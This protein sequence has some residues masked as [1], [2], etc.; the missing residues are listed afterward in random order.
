MDK[1]FRS[2][3][4]L[5]L[6]DQNHTWNEIVEL[7]QWDN[8][9]FHWVHESVVSGVDNIITLTKQEAINNI[10]NSLQIDF[11]INSQFEL[12]Y[13]NPWKFIDKYEGNELISKSFECV[14]WNKLTLKWWEPFDFKHKKLNKS[15][16]SLKK[17]LELPE[18][19]NDYFKNNLLNKLERINVSCR[20]TYEMK[21]SRA[22]DKELLWDF[23]QRI[24]CKKI[25]WTPRLKDIPYTLIFETLWLKYLDQWVYREKTKKELTDYFWNHQEY[26]N[27]KSKRHEKDV[28][29]INKDSIYIK[30]FFHHI[31]KNTTWNLTKE[32]FEKLFIWSW[33]K[34]YTDLSI[35]ESDST[36]YLK[37]SLSI[38]WVNDLYNWVKYPL[39]K[40]K[41]LLSNSDFSK[42]HVKKIINKPIHLFV[43]EDYLKLLETLFSEWLDDKN[44]K[45]NC[46]R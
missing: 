10:A 33:Y 26:S 4:I 25:F 24:A 35:K 31:L 30:Y 14:T 20:H 40:I 8:S 29:Y 17:I 34:T 28:R 5:E 2:K 36:K 16:R 3:V 38:I 41:E 13:L 32:D 45:K 1:N 43:F 19:N 37:N 42:H 18:K 15:I 6:L 39:W 9:C 11:W 27:D 7:F 23:Q 21:W 46:S 44:I 12:N 22:I